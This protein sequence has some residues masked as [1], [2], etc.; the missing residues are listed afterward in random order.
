[1][2]K[3]YTSAFLVVPPTGLYVREERCQGPVDDQISTSVRPPIELMYYAAMLEREGMICHIKDYP[4]ERSGAGWQDY[5]DDLRRLS[6]Q[7]VLI[8]ITS[9]TL[10]HDLQALERA[11]RA[12]PAVL[13]IVKGAHTTVYDREIMQRHSVIDIVLRGE[14]E[15]A[16]AEI[17]RGDPPDGIAGITFR[18]NGAIVRNPDRPFLKNLDELPF[19]ARHLVDNRHYRRPDTGAP[20]TTIQAAR[21]CPHGCIFCLAQVVAGAR[22]RQR[23]ARNIVDEIEECFRKY[24][25]ADF[26]LRADTFTADRP[27]VADLCREIKKRNLP[28]RWVSTTRVDMLDAECLGLM[29]QAG[30]WLLAFGIESGN[31]EILDKTH[32]GTS[33]SQARQAVALCRAAGIKTLVH[34]LIGLPWDSEKTIGDTID[35]L[36]RLGG[37][38]YEIRYCI[39]YPGTALERTARELGLLP[40]AVVNDFDYAGFIPKTLYLTEKQVAQL[41]AGALRKVIFRPAYLAKVLLND[42]SP[43]AWLNYFAFGLKKIGAMVLRQRK[44]EIDRWEQ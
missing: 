15:P 10:A 1:M 29:K 38:F 8:S 24:G 23:S 43:R 20:Q 28:V 16:V 5:E 12:N 39:P 13:T 26:F 17:G 11:K 18:N 4:V 41:R 22:L 19:P 40:R 35:F 42:P 30:C 34:S 25:I 14:A 37:D 33:L 3:R 27:W 7:I 6:P 31:Q 9:M 44:K 21:G 36:R 2:S 32:K